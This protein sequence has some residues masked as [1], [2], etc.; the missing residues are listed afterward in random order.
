MGT[1]NIKKALSLAIKVG[2]DVANGFADN[3]KLDLSEYVEIGVDIIG[4]LPGVLKSFKDI[5]AEFADLSAEERAE[6]IDWVGQEF[7]IHQDKIEEKI[8]KG[9][10]LINSIVEFIESF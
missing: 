7:D 3:G 5:K 8:E 9:L 1:E 4:G 10:Q 6:I 2:Q